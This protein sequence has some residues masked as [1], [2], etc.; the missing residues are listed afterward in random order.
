LTTVL[1]NWGPA[2]ATAIVE[3][4]R[5]LPVSKQYVHIDLRTVFAFI[6]TAA[7][8]DAK[9]ERHQVKKEIFRIGDVAITIDKLFQSDVV[10]LHLEGTLQRTLTKSYVEDLLHNYPPLAKDPRGVSVVHA[11]DEKR[12]GWVAALGLEDSFD[13]KTAF[14]PVYLDCVSYKHRRGRVFWRSMDRVREILVD[15]WAKAF[16][17]APAASRVIASAIK[18]LEHIS[19]R[20]T[21]SGVDRIFDCTLPS[22]P[23]SSQQ[24]ARIIAHFNGP[25]LIGDGELQQF[26]SDWEPLLRY[27]LVAAVRGSVR[28]IA[29]FKNEG[30]ELENILPMELFRSSELYLRGC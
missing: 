13:K 7:R 15:I 6:F 23:L 16:E 3:K 20:E 21:E 28:C 2:A 14:L 10:L 19:E 18:A 29:Y 4:P 24:N 9:R 1:N 17:G 25:P 26:R 22:P 30:R 5:V 27:V 8:N 12:G 11:G